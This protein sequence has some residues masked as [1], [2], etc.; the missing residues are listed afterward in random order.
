MSPKDLRHFLV[1]YRVAVGRADIS[2][3]SNDEYEAA[4]DAYRAAK[5]PTETGPASRLCS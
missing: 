2:E 1:V 4:L 3:Y 5:M